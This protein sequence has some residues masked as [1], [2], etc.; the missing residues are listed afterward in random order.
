MGS[1]SVLH[2]DEAGPSSRKERQEVLCVEHLWERATSL[3]G[4]CI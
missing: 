4:G 2:L 1:D 3:S